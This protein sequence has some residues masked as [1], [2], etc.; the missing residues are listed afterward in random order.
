MSKLFLLCQRGKFTHHVITFFPHSRIL[1]LCG[2]GKG[3]LAKGFYTECHVSGTRQSLCRVPHQHLAKTKI[4]KTQKIENFPHFFL[5][6]S[7]K[8]PNFAAAKI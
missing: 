1:R 6:F 4:K 8:I 5:A 7:N 2:S 3:R